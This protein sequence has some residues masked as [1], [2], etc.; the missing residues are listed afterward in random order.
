MSLYPFA[1]DQIDAYGR[2]LSYIWFPTEYEGRA[3]NIM[4]NLLLVSSP[5]TAVPILAMF[6]DENYMGIFIEAEG[7]QDSEVWSMAGRKA[8]QH[9]AA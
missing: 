5:V 6:F 4:F 8:R 7:L 3:Y 9:F 2:I 1:W